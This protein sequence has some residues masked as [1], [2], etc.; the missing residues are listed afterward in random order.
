MADI[1][2]GLVHGSPRAG[3][4]LLAI[5]LACAA[6]LLIEAAGS[7]AARR[8]PDLSFAHSDKVLH[9]TAHAG[10]SLLLFTALLMLGR[11]T[12]FA[13]RAVVAAAA[14]FAISAAVGLG[15]ELVQ[16]GPGAAHG[17]QF[18]PLDIAANTAG[19]ALA[20]GIA[21]MVAVRFARAYTGNSAG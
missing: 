3:A 9:A 13:R 19:A 18:D 16:S 10:L 12:T 15:A 20:L 8:L 7:P 21:L 5:A 11:P 1:K 2:N 14:A 17:R 4:L 6:L